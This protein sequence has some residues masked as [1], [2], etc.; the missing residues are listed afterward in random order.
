MAEIPTGVTPDKREAIP[1]GTLETEKGEKVVP[2]R[3]LGSGFIAQAWVAQTPAN[4][5]KEASAK[6]APVAEVVP[7]INETA[8]GE[9]SAALTVARA[10]VEAELKTLKELPRPAEAIIEPELVT[11]AK[12]LVQEYPPTMID[13]NV[14]AE[15][16]QRAYSAARSRKYQKPEEFAKAFRDELRKASSQVP[17]T[18]DQNLL[19]HAIEKVEPVSD[20]NPSRRNQYADWYEKYKANDPS[21]EQILNEL[22]KS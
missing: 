2:V 20:E 13:R 1:S 4:P 17:E 21:H 6:P 5:L 11:N 9:M 8:I 15:A 10:E 14:T 19:A 16:W 3:P 18:F 22:L 12:G 7:T